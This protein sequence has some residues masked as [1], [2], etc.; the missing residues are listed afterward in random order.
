MRRAF[1][2]FGVLII[3]LLILSSFAQAQCGSAAL[4]IECIS[5]LQNGVTY[6]RSFKVDGQESEV[7]YSY[8]FTKGTQYHIYTWSEDPAIDG[9]IIT[10]YDSDRNMITTN[11]KDGKF[12]QDLI[13]PCKESNIYYLTFTF[14]ESQHYCGGSVLGFRRVINNN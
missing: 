1:D 9:I 10:L 3:S 8:V 7:E 13:F 12:Y 11:Y 5:Q 2:I 6:L 14:R 4:E